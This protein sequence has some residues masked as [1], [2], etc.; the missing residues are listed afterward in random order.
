TCLL[1]EVRRRTAERGAWV[2]GGQAVEGASRQPFQLLSGIVDELAA[3]DPRARAAMRAALGASAA[4][5]ATIFPR[6][7]GALGLPAAP[8]PGPESL[9]EAR[10]L[11]ALAALLDALG[12]PARPALVVLD[13]CQWADDLTAKLLVHW[14][15]REREHACHVLVVASFRAEEVGPDAPLRAARPVLALRLAPFD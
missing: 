13:D 5:G 6:L 4:V 11:P 12:A 10:A 8:A 9:A 3:A 2:L 14:S 15:R 1:A 7:G